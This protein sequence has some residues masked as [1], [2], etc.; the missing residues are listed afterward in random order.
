[1]RARL[2]P[3]R[4]GIVARPEA[5]SVQQR[6]LRRTTSNYIC[7][8]KCRQNANVQ[9]FTRLSPWRRLLLEKLTVA[10]LIKN[11]PPPT[12]SPSMKPEYLF[13]SSQEPA[14]SRCTQSHES[15]PYSFR[16]ILIL[17]LN[18][19]PG[20]QSYPF[21]L[22]SYQNIVCSSFLSHACYMPHLVLLHLII[23]I[24]SSVECKLGRSSL[25]SL[26]PSSDTSLCPSL[27]TCI[28]TVLSRV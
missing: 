9:A 8:H 17:S 2:R 12:P 22:F 4:P 20:L 14:T 5:Q 19:Y 6:N 25:C 23:P 21:S 28:K 13:P 15:N 11:P 1:V 18:Q 7:D 16:F 10:Q 27:N 3:E 26:R 24:M